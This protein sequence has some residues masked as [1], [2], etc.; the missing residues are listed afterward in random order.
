MGHLQWT[1]LIWIKGQS[2]VACACMRA[3]RLSGSRPGEGDDMT[4]Y[5][6]SRVGAAFGLNWVVELRLSDTAPPVTVHR[7]TAEEDARRW[8][9]RLNGVENPVSDRW[10]SGR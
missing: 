7:F 9:A 3:R 1:P 8:A 2:H 4:T 5:T 6:V 10:P